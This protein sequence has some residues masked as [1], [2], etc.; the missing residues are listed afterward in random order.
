LINLLAEKLALLDMGRRVCGRV[1]RDPGLSARQHLLLLDE[2]D[3]AVQRDVAVSHILAN[4]RCA[5]DSATVN[6]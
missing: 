5:S 3:G 6:L 1:R 2:S 4:H